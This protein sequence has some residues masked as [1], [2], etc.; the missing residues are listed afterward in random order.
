MELPDL[1]DKSGSAVARRR[2]LRVAVK[3]GLLTAAAAFITVFL[4]G[5]LG[6]G[7]PS[8]DVIDIGGIPPGSARLEA[9]NGKPVWVVNRSR[10][11]RR[12]LE[13]LSDYVVTPATPSSGG[14]GDGDGSADGRYGIF[15]ADTDLPGVL[16]QYTRERPRA[17]AEGIPWY[18]G[19]IDPAG[20]A[21]FD[22]AGRRYCAT[23]GP[24]LAV[25]P[26]EYLGPHTV[27]FGRR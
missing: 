17:L 27:R 24:P 6:P 23:K 13:S 16:V 25:P 14:P 4:R 7:A 22:V 2:N 10:E 9:W 15:L 21:V 26:H 12:S 19:F 20:Q 11:Q 8:G 18:G 1:G 5:F 3:L